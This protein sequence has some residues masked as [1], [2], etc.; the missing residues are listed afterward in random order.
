[1][2]RVS[3]ICALAG[4]C[5][6]F[7]LAA[8]FEL[9]SR[10]V[11]LPLA[12]S[13]PPLPVASPFLLLLDRR[14]RFKKLDHFNSHASTKQESHARLMNQTHPTLPYFAAAEPIR[15]ADKPA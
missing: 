15:S 1:M 4:R 6:D 3:G 9:P 10:A 7:V 14:L 13:P 2:Y 11:S 8:S 5:V 12:E